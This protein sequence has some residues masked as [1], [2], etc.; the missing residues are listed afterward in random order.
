MN[1]NSIGYI[2]TLTLEN[3]LCLRGNLIADQ[4]NLDCLDCESSTKWLRT[5]RFEKQMI[6]T[7]MKSIDCLPARG[8]VGPGWMNLMYDN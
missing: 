8:K 2:M 3:R 6:L 1:A 7:L 4:V 5:Q